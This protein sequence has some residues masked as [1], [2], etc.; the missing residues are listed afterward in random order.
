MTLPQ[1]PKSSAP[2]TPAKTASTAQPFKP[3]DVDKVVNH[4]KGVVTAVGTF[5]E[6]NHMPLKNAASGIQ[7]LLQT[8]RENPNKLIELEPKIKEKFVTAR[9]KSKL[10]AQDKEKWMQDHKDALATA[11]FSA[12]Q[13][14]NTIRKEQ[15]GL[16]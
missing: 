16:K 5:G 9:E 14:W 8:H 6:K 4:L 12:E 7:L 15:L 10:F 3:T 11:L 13:L 2:A 1:R